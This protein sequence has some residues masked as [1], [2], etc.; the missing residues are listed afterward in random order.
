MSVIGSNVLVRFAYMICLAGGAVWLWAAQLSAWPT[1]FIG[2][3]AFLFVARA[4]DTTSTCACTT[5]GA[6]RTP[7][8]TLALLFA[9]VGIGLATWAIAKGGL[10]TI[11]ED[12][13]VDSIGRLC[14][15]SAVV[16]LAPLIDLAIKAKIRRIE[17]Q[18][19]D[20][21]RVCEHADWKGG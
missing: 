20:S 6:C 10:T 21:Q 4:T 2:L 1:Y 12:W 14:A 18:R 5:A 13:G 15:W 17:Q 3:A 16:V 9:S 11:V 19:D 8:L 7:N